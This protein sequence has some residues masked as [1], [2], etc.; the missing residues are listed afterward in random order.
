MEIYNA[1]LH[2]GENIVVLDVMT[3]VYSIGKDFSKAKPINRK[4]NWHQNE[5]DLPACDCASK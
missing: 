4:L 5:G 1:D 3:Y 2:L